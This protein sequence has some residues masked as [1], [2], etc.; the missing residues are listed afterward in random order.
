MKLKILTCCFLVSVLIANAQQIN[1]DS[2]K[3]FA[4]NS[5]LELSKKQKKSAH[6]LVITGLSVATVGLLIHVSASLKDLSCLFE[7]CGAS[8][9]AYTTGTVFLTV[10]GVLVLTSVP[11]YINS[12]KN[13]KKALALSV[14]NQVI[15]Q[16]QKNSISR[17]SV[18]SISVTIDL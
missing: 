8:K 13:K 9:S 6:A 17:V 14:S 7:D 16:M 2:T 15:Q 4:K 18:P 12:A 10:G 1:P 11:L 5:Y 3:L